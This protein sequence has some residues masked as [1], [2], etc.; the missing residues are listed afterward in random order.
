MNVILGTSDISTA[1]GSNAGLY[2]FKA[3]GGVVFAHSN[4]VINTFTYVVYPIPIISGVVTTSQETVGGANSG[5]R[6]LRLAGYY[7]AVP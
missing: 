4:F 3:F 5:D 6:I 1:T 7:L 2:P